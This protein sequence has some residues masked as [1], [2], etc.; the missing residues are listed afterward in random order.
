[1]CHQGTK[2]SELLTAF[3]ALEV[4]RNL[5]GDQRILIIKFTITIVTPNVLLI[6]LLLLTTH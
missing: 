5:M 4:T 1:M 3:L 2:C 6:S